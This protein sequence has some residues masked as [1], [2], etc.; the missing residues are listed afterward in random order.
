M[1][2]NTALNVVGLA[3]PLVFALLLVPTL[4]SH[5]GLERFGILTITWALLGYFGIF[6]LGLGR[7]TT[8]GL[9]EAL[10]LQIPSQAR[11]VLAVSIW[12]MLALGCIAGIVL[13]ML[14]PFLAGNLLSISP[15]LTAEVTTAL[16]SLAMA[17]PIV[18][19]SNAYVGALSAAQRFDLVNWV[20]APIGILN[21][22]LPAVVTV[23]SPRLDLVVGVVVA[24]RVVSCLIYRGLARKVFCMH[25][26]GIPRTW[27]PLKQL[28]TLG[29]WLTVSNVIGPIMV[30]LDRF[31]ISGLVPVKAIAYYTTPYEVVTRLWLFPSALIA[32][33]FP[34]F[35]GKAATSDTGLGPEY[36]RAMKV[37]AT[38]MM[39]ITLVVGG[40]SK[41]W[42]TLWIGAAFADNSASIVAILAV[43]VYI[44]SFAQISATLLQGT[45]RAALV[46]KIHL[47][48]L[49]AYLLLLWFC[50]DAYGLTGAALAWTL[51]ISID[52]LIMFVCSER[53]TKKANK[54]L[55]LPSYSAIVV[56]ALVLLLGQITSLTVKLA[57]TAVAIG[58]LWGWLYAIW[59]TGSDRRWLIETIASRFARR[60]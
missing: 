2:R 41:E 52:A 58:L 43:G 51:R 39:P 32:A 16:Y 54:T 15:D 13:A 10:A 12:A 5:L 27:R 33:L 28:M 56:V 46:A 47:I 9:S 36:S 48:E 59:W 45:G 21:Y 3:L 38:V 8:K 6:D 53:V 18:T 22:V 1:L 44:N 60:G 35:A 4:I 42:L 11:E 50:V 29:G 37:L 30:Y 49:P 40:L 24:T 31:L 19:V 7:A 17:L 25:G 14:T 57:C 23:W 20:R 55:S 26:S 34:I